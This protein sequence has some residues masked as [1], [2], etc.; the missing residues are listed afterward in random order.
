M[1]EPWRILVVDDEPDLEPLVLQRMRRQIR[2]GKY[3]FEFAGNGLEALEK[4]RADDTIDLVLSD[5]NMPQMDGLT[6][7]SQLS[8]LDSD[9]RAVIIS[10]YGD[11]GNIRT[12]MNRGA[13]DFVTKPVD[14]DD[15]QITIDRT[16]EHLRQWREATASR[17]KLVT[18]QNELDIATN[19]QQSILPTDFPMTASY[20]INANMVPARNVGGD[21]YD[22]VGVPS[23]RMFATVADVSDK[24]IP[25]ALFMMSSR[26]ALKG[27][28]IGTGS[29][30]EALIEANRVLQADNPTLMFVTV[31]MAVYDPHNG[32]VTYSSAGHDPPVVI[33][34]DGTAERLPAMGG[35]ALGV[36]PEEIFKTNL[37]EHTF[38]LDPG[39]TLLL[40]T[41]G[42]SEAMNVD[43]EEFGTARLLELF[44]GNPPTSADEAMTAVFNAVTEFAGEAPA[45]DDITCLALHR[46]AS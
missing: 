27:A 34:A 46:N 26:T 21:F 19:V 7:L 15:L 31:I 8:S 1:S 5:I 13:F 12:A 25:A 43:H 10:A 16:V 2:S 9:L 41:D 4:L 14:F 38:V 23:D 39:E 42:I 40:Y 18:L 3:Q 45:S 28:A 24:G 32:G 11:M 17:D 35:I 44:V 36:A 29:P 30:R 22:Y 6:L 37:K 20:E 33:R